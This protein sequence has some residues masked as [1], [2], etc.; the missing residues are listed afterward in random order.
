M[1]KIKFSVKNSKFNI[2]IPMTITADELLTQPILENFLF[3]RLIYL[4]IGRITLCII[5]HDG[6]GIELVTKFCWG[7]WQKAND[8]I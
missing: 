2:Y 7:S 8:K 1:R 3:A 4:V 5:Y 6:N